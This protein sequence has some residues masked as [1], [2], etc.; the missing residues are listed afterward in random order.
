LALTSLIM[1]VIYSTYV[2]T[3]KHRF[4]NMAMLLIVMGVLLYMMGLISE[5][6]SL[7]RLMQM[8]KK[9]DE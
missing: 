6:I 2:L 1:G 5:Q 7:L 3:F 4:S 8:E 9:H